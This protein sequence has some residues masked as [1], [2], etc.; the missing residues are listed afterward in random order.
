MTFKKLWQT[1]HLGLG[2]AAALV[3][4]S[5]VVTI[6]YEI[7]MRY[8]FNRPTTWSVEINAFAVVFITFVAAAWILARNRH[9]SVSFLQENL[10]PKPRAILALMTHILSLV[11]VIALCLLGWQYAWGTV[12]LSQS[13]TGNLE[14]PKFPLLVWVPAAAA[15]LA[16]ELVLQ[17]VERVKMLREVFTGKAMPSADHPE[18]REDKEGPY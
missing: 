12:A 17:V 14:I 1:F 2:Y 9:I 16:V 18:E 7:V 5:M 6:N 15:F 11:F 4:A 13:F 8:F 3:V 10:P